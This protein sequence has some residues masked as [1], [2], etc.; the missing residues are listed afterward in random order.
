MST[1]RLALGLAFSIPLMFA[2]A[3]GS[4][5]DPDPHGPDARPGAQP[6]APPA[7]CASIAGDWAIGGACGDDVAVR[8]RLAIAS[9]LRGGTCNV[10]AIARAVAMSRRSLER[11]LAL[12]GTSATALIDDERRRLALAWLPALS[13]DE[14]ATRLGYSDARAFAR[15]FRRWTGKAPS[16]VRRS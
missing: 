13:V 8:A 9:L 5:S 6:D 15:A 12:A 4:N 14:V 1:V 16:D 7:G 10:A 11:A 3:C 2:A